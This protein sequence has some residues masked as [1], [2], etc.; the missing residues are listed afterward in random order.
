MV[1]TSRLPDIVD[2]SIFEIFD[3][4]K[5]QLSTELQYP[6]LGFS[7]YSPSIPTPKFSSISGLSVAQLT[8]QGKPYSKE[9]F[10]QGYDVQATVKKYTKTVTYTEELQHWIEK[11]NKELAQEFSDDIQAVT[12]SL[13]ER[14]DTEAAK[15]VYL[16]HTTTFQ[17]GGD[18]VALAGAAHP[19]TEPGV[20]TQRNIFKTTEGHLPLS[21]SALVKARDRKTRFY[22]L[23]GVQMSRPRKLE[24]WIAQENLDNAERILKTNLLPGTE[25]NDKSSIRNSIKIRV[26]DWQPP[27]YDTYW[28]LTCKKRVARGVKMVNGWMPRLANETK[29]DNGTYYKNGSVYFTPVFRDWQWGH[30]SKGDGS[31]ISS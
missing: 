2:P 17:T 12:Q 11:G 20:S 4:A 8:L 7:N 21:Y 31:T 1:T 15:L 14:L 13:H 26:L 27:G 19:S 28:A 6:E 24:L 5:D 3:Q 23:K 22:D 10:T 30:F 9:D 18:A 25:L 29:Y 16:A